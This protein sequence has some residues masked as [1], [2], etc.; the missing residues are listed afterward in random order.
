MIIPISFIVTLITVTA[1]T[2]T[3]TQSAGTPVMA[4]VCGLM[5]V[6]LRFA[7]EVLYHLHLSWCEHSLAVAV[8]YGL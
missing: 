8:T 1:V 6:C 5:F 2:M 7:Q 4:S 3:H